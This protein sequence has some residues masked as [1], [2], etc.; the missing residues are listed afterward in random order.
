MIMVVVRV[1]DFALTSK[2]NYRMANLKFFTKD[3]VNFF[4]KPG[5]FADHHI[6]RIN[7]ATHGI[8]TRGNGPDMDVV[9]V[10]NTGNLSEAGNNFFNIDPLRRC[11][12]ENV[13]GFHYQFIRPDQDEYADHDANDGVDNKPVGIINDNG[14]DDDA[15]GRKSVTQHMQKCC[16]DIQAVL[17]SVPTPF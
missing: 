9:G 8:H 13:N 16:P 7:M 14:P 12:Q 1:V 6:F 3:A 15:E 5:G 17:M 4:G 10:V 2:L 11:F